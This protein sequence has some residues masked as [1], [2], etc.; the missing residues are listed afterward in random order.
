M[1]ICFWLILQRYKELPPNFSSNFG[2]LVENLEEEENRRKWQRDE[3]YEKI[4]RAFHFSS[5]LCIWL[6]LIWLENAIG[7]E[8]NAANAVRE[9]LSRSLYESS[10]LNPMKSLDVYLAQ[11]A[12]N[13]KWTCADLPFDVIRIAS[14]NERH[15]MRV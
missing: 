3:L 11:I 2:C 12:V 9:W 7:S 8:E 6:L 5:L 10:V 14:P 15:R 4:C 1:E 13:C